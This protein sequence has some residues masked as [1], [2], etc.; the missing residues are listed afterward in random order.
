MD[1][2]ELT[3]RL[4]QRAAANPPLGYRVLIDLG[5]DG[6]IFWDG[7]GAAPEI[8]DAPGEE[9]DSTIT[10]SADDL[11]KMVEGSLNPTLAYM[12]GRLKVSGSVGVALKISQ[13]LED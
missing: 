4:R 3:E 12:T 7:T 11:T 8:G 13:L 6:V 1:R 9:I 5:E 10:I 2:D